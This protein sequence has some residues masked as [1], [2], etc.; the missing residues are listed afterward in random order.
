MADS[1]ISSIATTTSTDKY[2]NTYTTSVSNDTLT[3]ED[4]LELMMTEMKYQD[5]TKPMDSDKMLQDQ[6]QLSTIDAN[7]KMTDAM[8]SLEKA[9]N[10][11]A[12]ADS[13]NMIGKIIEK[14]ESEDG[15]TYQYL[16]TSVEQK[17]GEI[18]L[19]GKQLTGKDED[20]N[21]LYSDVNTPIQ[22]NEI[23]K[24]MKGM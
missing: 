23:T 2:G 11:S 20:G 7:T 8:Q 24:I 17:D 16:I 4:F 21:V 6:M 14:G 10:Q 12:I 19:N 3:S 1:T 18:V 5:P 9:Y 15:N 22:Y 13:S